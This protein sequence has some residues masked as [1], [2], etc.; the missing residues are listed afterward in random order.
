M[1]KPDDTLKKELDKG[2]NFVDFFV[3][4]GVNRD[5]TFSDFLYENDLETLNKSERINPEILTKFPPFD[6]KTIK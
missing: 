5:L 2:N 1:K 4:I 6:K 3:T